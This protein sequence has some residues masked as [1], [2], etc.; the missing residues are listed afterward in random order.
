MAIYQGGRGIAFQGGGNQMFDQLNATANKMQEL[1]QAQRTADFRKQINESGNLGKISEDYSNSFGG[2]GN[3][4][5]GST[6]NWKQH[7]ED[8]GGNNPNIRQLRKKFG[9]DAT[10]ELVQDYFKGKVQ[11]R[12]NEVLKA[13]GRRMEEMGIQ[14]GD[15]SGIYKV[16]PKLNEQGGAEFKDW[17][18]NASEE[19]RTR[20]RTMGYTPGIEEKAFVPEFMER[21]LAQNKSAIS[22]KMK[23]TAALLGAGALVGAKPASEFAKARGRSSYKEALKESSK[24]KAIDNTRAKLKESQAK[25]KEEVKQLRAQKKAEKDGRKKKGY[26]KKIKAKVK[27]QR[28][29]RVK[30]LKKN[31]EYSKER[32]GIV[33]DIKKAQGAGSKLTQGGIRFG[34]SLARGQVG[35]FLGEK[36]GG[37]TGEMVGQT[38]GMFA[39]ELAKAGVKTKVG[40]SLISAIG[41]RIGIM[42][43]FAMADSPLPG[44]ADAAV[45]TGG[46]VLGLLDYLKDD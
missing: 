42:A 28:A 44:Y 32:R 9:P 8:L 14:E 39:P 46:V 29:D 36:I 43:P 34:K 31:L 41:K 21:R 15:K 17:Y 10:P 18:D 33:S 23:G 38:I 27:Q 40:K 1:R 24:L 19:T 4:Q 13:L 16:I 26:D 22:G 30:M 2:D 7:Y 3:I 6:K 20:L 12:D 37:E 5:I 25:L 35:G 45:V 11:T